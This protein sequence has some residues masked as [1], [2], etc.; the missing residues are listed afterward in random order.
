M[1]HTCTRYVLFSPSNPAKRSREGVPCA[2]VRAESGMSVF[3]GAVRSSAPAARAVDGRGAERVAR[4]ATLR[5]RC[6]GGRADLHDA[7]ELQVSRRPLAD[8]TL[9]E[10]AHQIGVLSPQ[11]SGQ[12]HAYSAACAQP[13]AALGRSGRER[14]SS[15]M[16]CIIK[17]SEQKNLQCTSTVCVN[18]ILWKG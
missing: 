11:V 8:D 15:E 9:L 2:P 6:G 13:E 18:R 10:Q 3:V 14:T 7:R 16:D 1:R 5:R 17:H 12:R 4:A